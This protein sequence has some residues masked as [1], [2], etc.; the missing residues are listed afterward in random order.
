MK[1]DL[2]GQIAL[3]TGAGRGLGEIIAHT[4]ATNGA[5]VI[6]ADIDLESARRSSAKSARGTPLLL[7]IA[8][9]GDVEVAIARIEKEHGRLDILVN[10]AGVSSP[11][12]V[13]IDQF[14]PSEWDRVVKVDLSGMFYVSRAAAQLMI[15]QKYGRII[16]IS[17]VIGVVPA[18][19]QCA[20]AAAKAGAVQLTKAMALE[21]GP[22]GILVNCVAPG[23]LL[24]NYR[25]GS[26]LK[27]LG[28]RLLSHVPLGRP[29]EFE[30]VAHA[31]LYFTARESSYVTGQTLS[32]DG[33]WTAGGFFRDF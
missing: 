16:N 18:R 11:N 26:P 32:V 14:P 30:D 23:S 6:Y 3:V 5:R 12:R 4:L 7:D 10:N 33:G 25:E 24:N 21:L 19:L 28:Q 17:S 1:V 8:K 9:T 20:Y 2:N 22:S 29:G 27:E 15:R 13:N 31:V